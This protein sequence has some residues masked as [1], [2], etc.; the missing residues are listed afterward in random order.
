MAWTGLS[1]GVEPLFELYLCRQ[2]DID[3]SS[4]AGKVNIKTL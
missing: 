1:G 2:H 4:C 3:K